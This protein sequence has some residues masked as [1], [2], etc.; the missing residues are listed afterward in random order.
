MTCHLGDQGNPKSEA[1]TRPTLSSHVYTELE[2][3]ARED[4]K[5]YFCPCFLI[6][7]SNENPS[8]RGQQ[9]ALLIQN[10]FYVCK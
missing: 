4:F 9:V 8:C 7:E 3:P 6:L 1:Q 10:G 2:V 5:Y